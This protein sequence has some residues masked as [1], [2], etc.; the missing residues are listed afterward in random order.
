MN[1]EDLLAM[2]L[3][4]TWDMDIFPRYTKAWGD[5]D[6]FFFAFT[7]YHVD[8]FD[9]TMW[10]HDDYS[11]EQKWRFSENLSRFLSMSKAPSTIHEVPTYSREEYRDHFIKWVQIAES[12]YNE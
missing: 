3:K 4:Y 7:N 2:K 12:I 11:E 1:K 9:T 8:I 10:W 5:S 6:I